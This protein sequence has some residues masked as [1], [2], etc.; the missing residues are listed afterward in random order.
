MRE[1]LGEIEYKKLHNQT[2]QKYY[3]LKII[4]SS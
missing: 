2:I 1:E 4:R 3:V